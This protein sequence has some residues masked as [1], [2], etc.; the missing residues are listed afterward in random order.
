MKK[1]FNVV[2]VSAFIITAITSIAFIIIKALDIDI[3]K[4]IM[5]HLHIG[6]GVIF[7]AFAIPSMILR[8]KEAKKENE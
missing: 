2:R 6:F 8:R 1:A 4:E 7:I 3:D 5:E